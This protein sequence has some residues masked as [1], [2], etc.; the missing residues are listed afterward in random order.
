MTHKTGQIKHN[1]KSLKCLHSTFHTYQCSSL[2]ILIPGFAV[3]QQRNR[4]RHLAGRAQQRT[5]RARGVC[6]RGKEAEGSLAWIKYQIVVAP[7]RRRG[8]SPKQT[9]DCYTPSSATQHKTRFCR[10]LHSVELFFFFLSLSGVRTRRTFF[11]LR[12]AVKSNEHTHTN[13]L[14]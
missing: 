6:E 5:E 3:L 12:F 10:H 2:E 8:W 11:F 13:E 9:R 14:V 4:H 7:C 1:D